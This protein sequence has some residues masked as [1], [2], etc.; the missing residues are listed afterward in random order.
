MHSIVIC[1]ELTGG[2]FTESLFDKRRSR[3]VPRYKAEAVR[4][5]SEL[6]DELLTRRKRQRNGDPERCMDQQAEY[7]STSS[8]ISKLPNYSPTHRA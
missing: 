3:S 2:F 6:D 8:H 4:A 1:T 5:R 7:I